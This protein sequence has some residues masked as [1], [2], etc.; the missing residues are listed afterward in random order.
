MKN[1]HKYFSA[2]NFYI[3]LLG[4]WLPLVASCSL[5]QT[6]VNLI[7]DA[8]AG[9]N[10]VYMSDDDPELIRAAL[11]FGLKTLESLL[12]VSPDNRQL[13]IAT[14]KGFTAYAYLIQDQADRESV[15]DVKTAKQLRQRARGL[16]LR[17]RDYALRGLEINY[18]GFRHALQDQRDAILARTDID[19]L[20]FLY[21]CGTA[22]AGAV[23]VAK[24]DPNLLVDLP[25]FGALVERVLVLD[26]AFDEGAA[27]EFFISFEA[28]R[29]GGSADKARFHYGR[30]RHYSH[31]ER[32]S[33]HL[34]LA[35]GVALRQQNQAEFKE[36]IRLAL[37]VPAQEL[38]HSRLLNTL[39]QQRAKWL[40]SQMDELFFDFKPAEEETK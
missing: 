35:E 36:L 26:E 6:A 40:L 37:S 39:S 30:A 28:N 2:T 16:Y 21:W 22:W 3:G 31:G 17:A 5:R 23:G 38:P 32:A 29:P 27:H 10:S 33:V 9:G 19:D 8:V 14:A 4:L 24:N 18:Q 34:A 7:G 12:E 11:P 13:L 20:P 1:R 15:H 25:I